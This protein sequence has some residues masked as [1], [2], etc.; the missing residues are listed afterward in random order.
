MVYLG[1]SILMFAI[2]FGLLFYLLP[3]ILGAFFSVLPPAMTTQWQAVNVRTQTVI[4]WLIPLMASLGIFIFILKTL[5][6]ATV[7][8]AD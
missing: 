6:A 4:Q 7:R 5:M 3:M 1:F 2:T 8:G